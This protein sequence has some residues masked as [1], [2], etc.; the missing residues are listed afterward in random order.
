MKH[1][2]RK[3]RTAF[4][5]FVMFVAWLIPLYNVQSLKTSAVSTDYPVQ[6]MNIS[7]KDNKTTL[8]ENG[9]ADSSTLS[10]KALGDNLAS[11]WRLDRVNKDSKG[12]FFKICSAESGR[13]L[14]PYGYTVKAGTSVIM[15]G[16]E[17]HQT[18][19]WYV[20]PVSQDKHGNDLYYKIVNYADTSLALTQSGSGMTLESYKG[21]D[22]Q[23]WLLNAD[24]LQGFAGYCDNDQSGNIKAGDIG[25]LFGEVVEAK[26]FDELKKYAESDTPYT[27]V[28]TN[29]IKVTELNLNKDRYMCTAGRIYVRNNKTIIGSY[30]AHTLFNV[31]FCTATS[32]GVGNNIIIKNFE[33]QHDAESN[34]NDSIVCYFGSGKNIW[35]DHVSFIG[36]ENYGYAP[37]TGLVDED[38][39]LACCYDADYCTVSDSSFGKHKY[40]VILG[41]PADDAGNKAKYGGYPRMSLI[42]NKFDGCSTRGPGLMRW[43]YFHSLNNYV[44][45]FSMA[46]TVM[47]D[48]NIYAENCN[49]EN[50]GNVIC[51]W[52]KATYI[53]HYTETGSVFSGCNRTQQG[54]DSNSTAD[55]SKWRPAGNYTYKKLT[56]DNAKTYCK[57]Y[58]GCQTSN[59]NM[60]YLRFSKKGVPNAGFNTTP[61]GAMT[62]APAQTTTTTKQTT[63]TTTTTKATTTTT[64]T[65]APVVANFNDGSAYRIKNADSGLYMQVA[66]AKA[67]NG[68][69][70]QQWG[71]DGNSVHDI[72]K[73]FSAG[74]GY[75]YIASCV[76]DGGTYVLDVAGKKADNGTNLDIYK[77]NGGTNQQFMLTKNDDGSYKIRTRVSG[78]KSVVEVA[79]ADKNSGAN[80]QEWEINGANCQNWILEPV[81]DAGCVMDESVIYTFENLNSGMGMEVTNGTMADKTNVQQWGS[82]GFDCQK[83]IL[84]SFG[85]GNY[86]WIRS[87]QDESYALK[88]DGSS[89]GGNICLTPYST[90]DSSQLFRFTKNIDGSYS[91]ITHASKDKCLVEVASA[92]MESG[93]N[94]QQWENT[95]SKCQRWKVSTEKKPVITTTTT[96]KSTTTT[97]TTNKPVT[98]TTTT[99]EPVTTVAGD[100]NKDGKTNTADLVLLRK[101][102]LNSGDTTLPD[103]K[104]GD[105]TGDGIL[106]VFDLVLMRQCIINN[107]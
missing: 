30:N 12:T 87:A 92:S 46:Y 63:T 10:M 28:V 45:N 89:N 94:V 5:A 91:I 83:W 20:V 47:S 2:Q 24:G 105:L 51:D 79:N 14:T 31:Q 40:G 4:L 57:T 17:S 13:L 58:S 76:G 98:T 8:T 59:G 42:S 62:T 15:Y 39:F 60:M 73:M 56:A 7:A 9:T 102:L 101:W 21:T 69:N 16:S 54:G 32:K 106:D 96:T 26:T 11:S 19:H 81:T 97:T 82:N 88:A 35:V 100:L 93:A 95:N 85:S 50:G 23:L 61:G 43:G 52:D 41:Y 34:N 49:Y 38:K 65:T 72:W 78:G 71:S 6:L 44:N 29:N 66:G 25:G 55:A 18:Q 104:S 103:W 84:K 77:Y 99:S 37:Q 33:M 80:V 36:H 67:E 68:A 75:Y 86:Y 70:V 1:T 74:D 90:K 22:N 53:G 27:I 64:T 3:Q 107:Q 48:V